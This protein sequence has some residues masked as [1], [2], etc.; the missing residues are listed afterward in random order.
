MR[1]STARISRS[2]LKL[3]WKFPLR[4]IKSESQ[5]DEAIEVIQ[6]LAIRGENG[7]DRGEAIISMRWQALWSR[8]KTSIIRSVPMACGR[9]NG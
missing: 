2:Y 3:V 4:V 7:L 1:L 5:Y 9:M 8:M 6:G